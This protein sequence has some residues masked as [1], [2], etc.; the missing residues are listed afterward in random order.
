MTALNTLKSTD[1]LGINEESTRWC[2]DRNGD[3]MC[4]KRNQA[5]EGQLKL[6]R[7]SW[8]T[9]SL[10]E[11]AERLKF[12]PDLKEYDKDK[13]F[14]LHYDQTMTPA[15]VTNASYQNPAVEYSQTATGRLLGGYLSHCG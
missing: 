4:Y 6:N 11:T 9:G 3:S 8:I 2:E 14:P 15:N 13:I 12:L 1:D 10:Q 7:R 5:R